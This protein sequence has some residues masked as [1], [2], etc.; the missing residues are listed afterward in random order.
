MW[1]YID[2][3]FNDLKDIIKDKKAVYL[4]TPA[5]GESAIVPQPSMRASIPATN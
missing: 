4:Q 3:R 1:E 5:E 2:N